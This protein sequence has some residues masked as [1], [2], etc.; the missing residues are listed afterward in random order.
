MDNNQNQENKPTGETNTKKPLT[1][2][3]MLLSF[4]FNSIT[5]FVY[6]GLPFMIGIMIVLMTKFQGAFLNAQE[7]DLLQGVF[8]TPLGNTFSIL[9]AVASSILIIIAIFQDI[10]KNYQVNKEN[11]KKAVGF[12][13][14]ILVIKI[15]ISANVLA[16][17]NTAISIGLFY[18]LMNAKY[19]ENKLILENKVLTLKNGLILAV[20]FFACGFLVMYVY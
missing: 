13:S 14:I 19:Q 16:L 7:E 12:L 1:F 11:Y 20:L 10:V 3:K 15:L 4:I 9:F 6:L 18:W 2:W 17:I 5:V 8:N